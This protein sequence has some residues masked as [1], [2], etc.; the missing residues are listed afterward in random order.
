MAAEIVIVTV[1]QAIRVGIAARADDVVNAGP[2]RIP[3]LPA[4]R[5]MTDGR[6]RPEMRQG[7]P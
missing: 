1:Q 6:H 2:I 7:A 3:A 4:E 5:V